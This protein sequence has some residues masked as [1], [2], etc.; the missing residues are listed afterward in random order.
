MY[1]L[2]SSLIDNESG[3]IYNTDFVTH[4]IAQMFKQ[5]A[6]NS[7]WIESPVVYIEG[8]NLYI[9]TDFGLENPKY[10]FDICITYIKTP[11]MF[12]SSES[13]IVEFELSEQMAEELINLAILFAT[14]ITESPRL[15]SKSSTLQLES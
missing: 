9:L 15:Q 10:P 5:T 12:D 7:P 4:Q 11:E 6:T 8:K 14:E 3:F 2:Q 13:E 1:Y